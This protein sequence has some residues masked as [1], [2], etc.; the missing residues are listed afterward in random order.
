VKNIHPSGLQ[1][2]TV[3]EKKTKTMAVLSDIKVHI[4]GAL[5]KDFIDI[6]LN[7]SLYGFNTFSVT[8]R[9]DAIEDADEFLIEKSKEY[10]GAKILMQLFTKD[11]NEDNDKDGLKFKGIITKI[12][13]TRNMGDN[14]SILLEGENYE[15]LLKSKN[16]SRSFVGKSLDD[17]VTEVLLPYDRALLRPKIAARNKQQFEYL[18]QYNESDLDFLR[19]LSIRFGEWFYHDNDELIFGEKPVKE[20]NLIIGED[21]REITYSIHAKPIKFELSA[22][23][24]ITRA[25]RYDI[26]NSDVN[27]DSEIN[28]LGKFAKKKAEQ[29]FPELAKSYYE[30]YG[31]TEK[32]IKEA[33]QS[34]VELMAKTDAINLID[35]SGA[36]KTPNIIVGQTA[37]I[38]GLK[39]KSSGTTDYGK[40]L[41]TSCNYSFDYNLGFH[42]NFSGIS[43]E[44]TLP[45]YTDPGFIRQCSSQVAVVFDNKDP[46]KIGRIKVRFP[47]MKP[48]ESTHWITMN[49]P[50]VHTE[51]GFY[52]IPS[53]N[54]YAMVNFE[55]GDVDRPFF[56]GSFYEKKVKPD[57]KWIGNRDE[58]GAKTLAIRSASGQTIEMDDSNGEEKIRIYDTSGEN[59]IELNCAKGELNIKAKGS[60]NI[61][62]GGSLKIT[63]ND[64]EMDAKSDITIKSGATLKEEGSNIEIKS[65]GDL[66]AGGIG[67]EIRADANLK[68]NSAFSEIQSTSKMSINGGSGLDLKG[69][70]IQIN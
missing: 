46:E 18:V 2:S 26:T 25:G 7:Q 63:A 60:I 68:V 32:G 54:T 61:N 23:E 44:S 56:D 48:D 55:G 50:Y 8:C 64:I 30:N 37:T 66:K 36:V 12:S 52:F 3:P 27:S 43:A 14:N 4:N 69:A 57:E 31:V 67:I 15:A 9:F 41:I 28:M 33:L 19:R 62:A 59:E 39:T 21:V 58:Y 42:C 40:F 13:G 20:S 53:K 65:G 51:G 22:I 17:I 16:R 5:F 35:I 45:E 1:N 38:K 34:V 29:T 49:T 11:L 24:K 6:Q 70:V 10:L 47:W